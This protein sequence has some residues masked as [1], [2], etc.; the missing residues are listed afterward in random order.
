MQLHKPPADSLADAWSTT[1][2]ELPPTTE[3]PV[4]RDLLADAW[5]GTVKRSG[6]FRSR[7]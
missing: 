3:P 2:P 1:I 7:W 4:S 6:L 5:N